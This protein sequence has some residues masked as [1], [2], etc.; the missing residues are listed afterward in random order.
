MKQ[1][2]ITTVDAV[3][4]V[5]ACEIEAGVFE[6]H[7]APALEVARKVAAERRGFQCGHDSDCAIHNMP[8]FPAGPCDCSVRKAF[9]MR[10]KHLGLE[11]G[12]NRE[13]ELIYVR[14]LAQGAWLGFNAAIAASNAASRVHTA[15]RVKH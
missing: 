9:E 3:A 10:F 4:A 5:L 15:G 8:A 1:A 14:D 7:V 11:P 2:P 13:N 6:Q 12:R